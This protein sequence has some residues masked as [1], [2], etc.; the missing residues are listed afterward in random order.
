M[1]STNAIALTILY[2]DTLYASSYKYA[3][4]FSNYLQKCKIFCFTRGL[5]KVD[6]RFICA[7]HLSS[8]SS[9]FNTKP[10]KTFNKT[11]PE[12]KIHKINEKV[13]V[14][15]KR[16]LRGQAPFGGFSEVFVVAAVEVACIAL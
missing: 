11:V 3:T 7:S 6:L 13:H 10:K 8:I 14:P 1:S 5:L 12:A 4:I 16:P 9:Y 15:V 2:A